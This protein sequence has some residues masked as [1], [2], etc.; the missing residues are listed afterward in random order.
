MRVAWPDLSDDD[1]LTRVEYLPRRQAEPF[2]I[3]ITKAF[4]FV[5]RKK[6]F[7]IGSPYY[8]QRVPNQSMRVIHVRRLGAKWLYVTAALLIAVGVYTTYAMVLDI[9]NRASGIRS[10]WPIAVLVA[11]ITIPFAARDRYAVSV[12][13]LD[14]DHTWKPPLVISIRARITTAHNIQSIVDGARAAGILVRDDRN[15]A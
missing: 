3:T 8:I 10:G 2:A 15:A 9:V 1:V 4:V 6:V 7:S 11:G 14:G 5:L 12:E 13:W